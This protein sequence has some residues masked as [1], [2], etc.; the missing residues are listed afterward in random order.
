MILIVQEGQLQQVFLQY[1]HPS[2]HPI[3]NVKALKRTQSIDSSQ[4]ISPTMWLLMEGMSI[5]L[6]ELSNALPI[7][8]T[9][10]HNN[11]PN[12]IQTQIRSLK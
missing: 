7:Q 4:R 3:N 9:V 5:Y 12:L 10:T 11:T 2:F 6:Y 8:G 1:R